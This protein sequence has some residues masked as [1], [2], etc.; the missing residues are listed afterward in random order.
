MGAR[1]LETPAPC[2]GAAG[3]AS[4]VCIFG[5]LNQITPN[6]ARAAK[7]EN[8]KATDKNVERRIARCQ[9]R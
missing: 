3:A 6:F 1:Y 4:R 5:V 8:A 7:A 2:T 9:D